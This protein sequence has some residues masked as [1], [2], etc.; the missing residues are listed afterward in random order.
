M[1]VLYSQIKIFLDTISDEGIRLEEDFQLHETD[2]Y[3]WSRVKPT[4]PWEVQEDIAL[5]KYPEY[6]VPSARDAH[7]SS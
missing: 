4:L 7:E 1:I 2:M 6:D 3:F 5:K